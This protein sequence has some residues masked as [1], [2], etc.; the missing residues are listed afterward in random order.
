MVSYLSKSLSDTQKN[1][2]IH[3]LEALSVI[4]AL[5]TWNAY[6]F[7]QKNVDIFTDSQAVCWLFKPNSKYEGRAL[8]WA[9]R[10]GRWPVTLHH[11]KGSKNVLPDVLSR[12]PCTG[13]SETPKHD[14]EPLCPC[15]PR[16]PPSLT[17][18]HAAE[19]E[20]KTAKYTIAAMTR[21]QSRARESKTRA[22]QLLVVETPS[23]NMGT[24]QFNQHSAEGAP[25][26][27]TKTTDAPQRLAGRK[28]VTENHKEE[29]DHNP[30]S[31]IFPDCEF[32]DDVLS[33]RPNLILWHKVP[34][35]IALFREHQQR[36]DAV[37]AIIKKLSK[38]KC[39]E[40]CS[41][42]AHTQECIHFRWRISQDGLLLRHRQP[43]PL[44]R[45]SDTLRLY[46]ELNT[47]CTCDD[48]PKCV[49]RNFRIG[50][51]M[52]RKS[53]TRKEKKP[54]LHNES[55]PSAVLAVSA[56]G[57]ESADVY[58]K[59]FQLVV[60]NSLVTSVLYHI[61]GSGVAGHPG[62]TKAFLRAKTKFWWS[63][64]RRDVR[65][66]VSACLRCQQ[67]KPP[68]PQNA[69]KPGTTKLPKGPMQE[70][71][72]DFSG[73]FEETARK[74]KWI[75]TMVCAYSRY[76][77]AVPLPDRSAEGV[78]HALLEHVIQHYA[79]PEIIISDGAREFVGDVLKDFCK[80]FNIKHRVNPAY[81]PSLSSYVERYHAWQN[82]CITIMADRYKDS[83]DVML[84]LIS[85]SYRT[86]IQSSTGF[87]P[88]EAL[89][90]YEPKM[91]YDVWDEWSQN[92]P[93]DVDATAL[94]ERMKTLY[95]R[96]RH[97]HDE[98]VSHN[99]ETRKGKANERTFKPGDLV[100]RFAPKTS[101]V[102]PDEITAKGKLMDRWSLP[103]KVVACG[104]K[105]IYIVRDEK[106]DLHDAR[107]DCLRPF[108]FFTDGLP[109]IPAR[110]KFSKPERRAMNRRHKQGAMK[111]ADTGDM[112]IFPMRM[113]HG[114]GYGV[115]K[116]ISK[117]GDNYDVQFYSNWEESVAPDAT[118]HPCWIN[119]RGKYYIG[120]RQ[121]SDKPM[122]T[123]KYYTS[124]I[125]Q[126]NFAAVD[127]KL[128][129]SAKLPAAA[130]GAVLIHPDFSQT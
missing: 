61:H 83:W 74:N 18:L 87:S 93:E 19:T 15:C 1:Y 76:P 4:Y 6:L 115:G 40:G 112:V 41:G 2:A 101:E 126:E 89:R 49:H 113:A 7:G 102:L 99:L 125:T 60:P 10:A 105:G 92:V 116:V 46:L 28:L 36:D 81:S 84:P 66:W 16:D 71:Y 64:M 25:G 104:E 33:I 51:R 22:T 65:R 73:P 109:S 127:F 100:L 103:N 53:K 88:F 32:E 30:W 110:R 52:E 58:P 120:D 67:R 55:F 54:S 82:A 8:R 128:L 3:E 27:G 29:I 85:L 78:V 80:V 107:A 91:P 79:C 117:S 44:P 129:K 77:I 56:T 72:F 20:G 31:S 62:M 14:P 121:G 95:Q 108:S 26:T 17:A 12:L 98:A 75:L 68:R 13:T 24:T 37:N 21:S 42:C 5:E 114:P 23:T 119:Q 50:P 130:R 39:S 45:R 43:T 97:A 94:R 124:D 59:K 123:S 90:G 9:L 86:T 118:F 111:T 11:V 69:N 122:L 96:I 38:T 57:F 35:K 47:P 34:D 106:G 48:N 70:I 63:G